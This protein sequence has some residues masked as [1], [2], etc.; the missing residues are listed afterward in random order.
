MYQTVVSTFYQKE[1][2]ENKKYL[3]MDAKKS[4]FIINLSF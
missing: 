4:L 1:K 3:S 2:E